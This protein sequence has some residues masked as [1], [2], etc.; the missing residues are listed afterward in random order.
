MA[1]IAERHFNAGDASG[2]LAGLLLSG[3]LAWGLW[4]GEH[5]QVIKVRGLPSIYD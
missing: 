5:I 3:F 2:V 1:T 4:R